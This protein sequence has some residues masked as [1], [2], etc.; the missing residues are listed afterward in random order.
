[1]LTVFDK[2]RQPR[3]RFFFCQTSRIVGEFWLSNE[4]A[5]ADAR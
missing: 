1:M 4:E 3:K 2:W 5:L